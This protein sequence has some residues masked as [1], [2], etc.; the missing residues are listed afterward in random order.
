M[1]DAGEPLSN[2]PSDRDIARAAGHILAM[3][4]ETATGRVRILFEDDDRAELDMP[5][6]H[7]RG[8]AAAALA[9]RRRP[10]AKVDHTWDD[11]DEA[12]RREKAAV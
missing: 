6:S 9:F 5:L 7:L 3:R 4:D 1:S 2:E 12:I 8:I 10:K 11:V